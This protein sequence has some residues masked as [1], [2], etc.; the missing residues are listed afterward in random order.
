[1]AYHDGISANILAAITQWGAPIVF[2][3]AVGGTPDVY[4]ETTGVTTPGTAATDATGVAM[5]TKS[6]PAALAE[7]GLVVKNPVTLNVSAN[8]L[9]ITPKYGMPFDWGGERYTVVEN[10]PHAPAGTAVYHTLVG[11]R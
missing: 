2:P 1:M 8:G 5:G 7:R 6:D 4:D 9:G 10:L 3:G 11:D